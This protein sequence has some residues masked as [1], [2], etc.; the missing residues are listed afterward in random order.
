MKPYEQLLNGSI[1]IERNF[2]EEKLYEK[3]SKEIVKLK[4]SPGYQPGSYY[5]GN[6][7]QGYPTYECEWSKYK[8]V[9]VDRMEN[10]LS[11]KIKDVSIKV[12]RTDMDEVAKSKF[13]TTYG[14]VHSDPTDF[15]AILCFNQTSSGGTVFFEYHFDKYPDISIG[16]FPN[17][18]II[19]DG[20]R[21]H[22]TGHDFTFKSVYKLLIFFNKDVI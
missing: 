10:L 16:A 5:Y 9:I 15:G 22:T 18:I 17:R 12:R 20:K 14:L 7:F 1:H 11:C 2:F 8:K 4:Y 3:I 6:R 21:N 19:F 13:N